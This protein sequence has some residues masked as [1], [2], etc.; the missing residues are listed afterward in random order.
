MDQA[1]EISW[2][3]WPQHTDLRYLSLAFPKYNLFPLNAHSINEKLPSFLGLA[4]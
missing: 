2:T 3:C 1:V 4:Y